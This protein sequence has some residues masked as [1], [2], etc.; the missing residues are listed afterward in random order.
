MQDQRLGPDEFAALV[1]AHGCPPGAGAQSA[2]K[3]CI[4]KW[5]SSTN[6]KQRLAAGAVGGGGGGA[7]AASGHESEGDEGGGEQQQGS[8]AL[9]EAWRVIEP[10][11]AAVAQRYVTSTLASV[12]VMR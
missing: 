11:V 6:N 10:V 9:W 1:R 7:V 8:G 3:S 2:L 12:G 5:R 4:W